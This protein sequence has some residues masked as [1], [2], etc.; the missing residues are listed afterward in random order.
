MAQI[1]LD[2]IRRIEKER[3]YVHEKVFTTYS[4]FDFA[5]EKYVQLDTYGRSN[6]ELLGKS[7]QSIQL[8][9]ESAKFLVKLLV[10]EFDLSLKLS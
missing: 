3:N 1:D 5:G 7:S 8:D 9:K 6:R 10:N 2:T 4:A